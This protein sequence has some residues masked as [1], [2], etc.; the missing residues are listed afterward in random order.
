VFKK[1]VVLQILLLLFLSAVSARANDVVV[2]QSADINPYDDVLD[3]FRSSCGCNVLDVELGQAGAADISNK[4]SRFDPDMVFVIGLD[5]LSRAQS[6]TDLPV[7]Y[8]MV[9]PAQFPGLVGNNMSGVSMR[10]P[11]DK[12]FAAIEEVFPGARRVGIIYDPRHTDAFIR[13]ALDAAQRRGMTLVLK[14]ADMA[15]EVPSLIDAMRGKIDVFLMVPDVTVISPETVKY[16]LFFS[17]RNNVP[18][19]SFSN[20][21]VEMGAVAALNVVPFDIGLQA[22]EMAKRLSNENRGG[23]PIRLDARKTVLSINRTVAGKLGIRISDAVLKRAKDV[24]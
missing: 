12:Y 24:Y 8:S 19:F 23:A 10:I 11:A 4:L 3:G 16:L 21:Y 15:S 5:A 14:K 1:A 2:L 7:I 18:V 13:E 9:L 22:G 20:K 6:V 17:F